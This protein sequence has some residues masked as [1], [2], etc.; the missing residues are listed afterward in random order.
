MGLQED[1]SKMQAAFLAAMTYHEGIIEQPLGHLPTFT[2][3]LIT[4]QEKLL[5]KLQEWVCMPAIVT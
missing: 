2:I 4:L 1:V 5:V 3:V